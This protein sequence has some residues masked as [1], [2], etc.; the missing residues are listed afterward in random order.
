[1]FVFF[2]FEVRTSRLSDSCPALGPMLVKAHLP[3]R[4][5][6]QQHGPPWKCFSARARE[7]SGRVR[8]PFSNALALFLA[9]GR[10]VSEN[11]PEA[12]RRPGTWGTW[13]RRFF[14][15]D[16]MSFCLVEKSR[17]PDRGGQASRMVV[18]SGFE[19]P[20]RRSGAISRIT[21]TNGGGIFPLAPGGQFALRG[22]RWIQVLRM[23]RAQKGSRFALA[24][25]AGKKGLQAQP[26][27]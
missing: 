4:P 22:A 26:V 11:V 8:H 14:P 9:A 27:R 21:R 17:K 13:R 24:T 25:V 19:G 2:F 3:E 12:T 23:F 1:M 20:C 15:S 5:S 18:W 7:T 16:R 6:W 10:S